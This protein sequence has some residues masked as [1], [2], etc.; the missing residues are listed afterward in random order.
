[1][2]TKKS[3]K[4]SEA[5]GVLLVTLAT[6]LILGI[7]LVSFLQLIQGRMTVRARAI[8]WNQ[9]IPVL[10]SGIEEAF[11]H[12]LDDTTNLTANAWVRDGSGATV[13]YRKTQ[14][15]SDGTFYITTISNLSTLP[16]TKGII[17]SQGFVPAPLKVGYI[18]R[19]VMV[20]ATNRSI[21]SHAI[22]ARGKIDLNGQSTVDS[23]DS[24][25]TNYSTGHKYD[26]SKRKSGG[27][28]CH[29]PAH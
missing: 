6:G 7:I 1:M 4:R 10:E 14:T 12:L 22:A 26:A 5:G 21:F 3:T 9:A 13:T 27:S 23:Y 2:N 28:G 8:S 19:K 17:Y 18:A 16:Y 25:S 11:T 20:T 15:N 24:S 29:Q